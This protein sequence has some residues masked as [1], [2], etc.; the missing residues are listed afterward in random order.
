LN[1]DGKT[2]NFISRM[3]RIVL[4]N[5]SLVMMQ[6]KFILTMIFFFP[7]GHI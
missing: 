4:E 6:E 3:I 7:Q 2:L 5:Q 1:L